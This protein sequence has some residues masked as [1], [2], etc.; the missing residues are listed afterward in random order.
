M[1]GGNPC[2]TIM[3]AASF[4]EGED[5]R[6]KLRR[7]FERSSAGV[8]ANRTGRRRRNSSRR[9]FG[10][11]LG[12]VRVRRLTRH[13]VVIAVRIG[14]AIRMRPGR[15]GASE[16]QEIQHVDPVRDVDRA[17]VVCIRSLRTRRIRSAEEEEV[18]DE[19]AVGDIDRRARVG[20]T[21]DEPASAA[22]VASGAGVDA[23]GAA[24]EVPEDLT[25]RERVVVDSE[26]VVRY[27]RTSRLATAIDR[28]SCCRR[29][30]RRG[31]CAPRCPRRPGAR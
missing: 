1:D 12:A 24:Q 22:T 23:V 4:G 3:S 30:R 25:G 11:L 28:A 26:L 14:T 16:E 29:S 6:K 8:Q 13:A 18:E 15:V 5:P 20:V 19:D 21:T 27:R 7:S 2:E 17:A 10:G 9:S 31:T